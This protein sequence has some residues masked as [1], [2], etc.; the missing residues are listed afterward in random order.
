[1]PKKKGC[2]AKIVEKPSWIPDP[3]DLSREG[4][5]QNNLPGKELLHALA[6]YQ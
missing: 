5:I 2:A 6:R 4:V 1:M 3:P